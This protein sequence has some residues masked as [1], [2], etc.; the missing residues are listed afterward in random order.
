MLCLLILPKNERGSSAYALLRLFLLQTICRCA[1]AAAIQALLQRAIFI[2]SIFSLTS[3]VRQARNT[4]YAT[5]VLRAAKNS[6]CAVKRWHMAEGVMLQKAL[7]KS[8]VFK[9]RSFCVFGASRRFRQV[10][11]DEKPQCKKRESKSL[12]GSS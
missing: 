8:A 5:M 10:V 2:Y 6:V 7:K 12:A 9:A 1:R 4:V 3:Q 11:V